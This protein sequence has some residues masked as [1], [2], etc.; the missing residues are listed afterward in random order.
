MKIIQKCERIE[1]AEGNCSFFMIHGFESQVLDAMERVEIL[2]TVQYLKKNLLS[3]YIGLYYELEHMRKILIEQ[4]DQ[5][6]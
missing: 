2:N 6:I 5:S 4:E 1:N 3:E